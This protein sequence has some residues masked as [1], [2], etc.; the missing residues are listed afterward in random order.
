MRSSHGT[1]AW[2]FERLD[3]DVALLGDLVEEREQRSE[4]WYWRQVLFAVCAGM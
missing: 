3:L 2:L 1:A 4:I